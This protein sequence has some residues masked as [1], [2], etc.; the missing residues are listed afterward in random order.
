[1]RKIEALAAVTNKSALL[2]QKDAEVNRA[3][4]PPR[5]AEDTQKRKPSRLCT[6]RTKSLAQTRKKKKR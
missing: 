3:L 2:K 1:M 4:P 5:A 6:K